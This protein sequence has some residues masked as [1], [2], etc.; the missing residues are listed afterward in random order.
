[1]PDLPATSKIPVKQTYLGKNSRIQL[2]TLTLVDWLA[3]LPLTLAAHWRDGRGL[4]DTCSS[5][6]C[7]ADDKLNISADSDNVSELR[8]GD[9]NSDKVLNYLSIMSVMTAAAGWVADTM[10]AVRNNR[11]HHITVCVM[12][13]MTTSGDSVSHNSRCQ[14]CHDSGHK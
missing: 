5:I 12:S 11:P 4:E 14:E 13:V 7:N 1:M 8:S 10:V 3:V 6:K 9:N 2:S